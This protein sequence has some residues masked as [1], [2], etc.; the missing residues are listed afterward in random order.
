MYNVEVWRY[1]RRDDSNGGDED[2]LPSIVGEASSGRLHSARACSRRRKSL[3]H[4]DILLVLTYS[5]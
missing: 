3:D 2:L 5:I 1:D 4:V